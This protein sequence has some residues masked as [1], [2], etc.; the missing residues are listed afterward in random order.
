MTPAVVCGKTGCYC[1]VWNPFHDP[2]PVCPWP[3]CK[4][5]ATH[6]LVHRKAGRGCEHLACATHAADENATRDHDAVP[7]T[8]MFPGFTFGGAS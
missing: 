5:A 2:A 7:L 6:M 3:K 4:S 1:I 8:E